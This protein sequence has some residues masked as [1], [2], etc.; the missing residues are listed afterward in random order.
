LNNG[1]GTF[2]KTLACT[3]AI[4]DQDFTEVDFGKFEIN[5][6]DIDGDGKSDVIIHKAMYV[7]KQ[8]KILG[9]VINTW[10][11]F[12]KTYTYWMRSN[13][14]TLTQVKSATSNKADDAKSDRYLTGDFNGDG[15]VDLM[16]YGYDCYNG[17]IAN[18]DPVWRFYKNSINTG[19]GKISSF[20][21]S[22]GSTT[23]VN[24]ASFVG[25]GIYT[26]G[27]GSVYPVA[28]YTV[29]LHAVKSVTV[30][31]GA[32]GSMTTNYQY[33]G[34]KMHLQGRG[35]LGLASRTESNTTLGTV[36][37]SGIN[38]WN[39]SFY[40]PAATYTKTTVDGK[41]AETNVTLSVTDKGSKKYFP[42]PSTKTDKD[43]DGNIVT[44]TYQYNTSYGYITEE[45]ADF[46]G[47]MYKTVQYGNYILAGGGYKPQLVTLIQKHADDAAAFTKKTAITYDAAKGY[48]TQVTGNYDSSLPL[49]TG[50]TYDAIGNVLTTVESGSG[51]IPV[52]VN[53]VYDANYRF[54]T[55]TVTAPA[56][57]VKSYTYD[58]WGNVLTQKDETLASDILT[59]TH[60]YD[61]WGNRT[62][63]V[64]P[65]GTKTTTKSGWNNNQSKRYFVLTQGTG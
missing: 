61:N 57:S 47:G 27:T 2:T 6:C 28:D 16:N 41:T 18:A 15:Q 11:E 31:N 34:L 64:F 7:K 59:T 20:T 25:G 39:T 35:V 1:N 37:E 43:L 56:S 55:K 23:S 54:L 12:E 44:T 36:T 48:R 24:Y 10:G 26:K 63:T 58:T 53:N 33:G 49:T 8:E 29:P 17:T 42:F 40:V 4:Y 32:A 13:G 52:T 22:Y 45:K 46:G 38:T 19:N 62:S 51:I 3:L 14:S 60:T 5:V 50:Y 65:D 30:N 9:I 21:D